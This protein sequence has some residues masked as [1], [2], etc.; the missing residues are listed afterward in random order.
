MKLYKILAYTIHEKIGKSHTKT[1]NLKYQLQCE[2]KNLN[3]LMGLFSVS[4]IQ[5]YLDYIFKKLDTVT[6]YPPPRI[7]VN[8]I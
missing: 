1:I 2:I 6:D 5:D 4:N 8:K 7:Y 3:Y